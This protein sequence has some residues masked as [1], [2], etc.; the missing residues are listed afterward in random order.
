MKFTINKPSGSD[1]GGFELLDAGTYTFTILQVIT[2]NDN[3]EPLVARTGTPYIKV[4]CCEKVSGLRLTHCVFLDPERSIKVY[5]FLNSIDLAP[6]VGQEF[7][8]KPEDWIHRIFRGKVEVKND[9]NNIVATY[10]FSQT[11][12]EPV[13]DEL[14]DPIPH[15]RPTTTED[16]D[17]SEDV[18]F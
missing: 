11:A 8:I 6:E 12:P 15:D 1:E 17:L 16:P 5:H 10:A 4:Q 18:P 2:T 13:P 3:D 14:S 7:E 9:R